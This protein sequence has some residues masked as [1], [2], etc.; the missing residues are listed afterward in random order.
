MHASEWFHHPRLG[1]MHIT[2][3]W[4][5]LALLTGQGA[6]DPMAAAVGGLPPPDSLDMRPMLSGANASSC[7]AGLGRAG[8]DDF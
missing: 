2:D 6:D 8:L 3:W 4:A 5:T 7:G 1:M